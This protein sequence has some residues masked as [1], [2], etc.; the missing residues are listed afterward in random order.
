MSQL[1]RINTSLTSVPKRCRSNKKSNMR[2]TKWGE[3]WEDQEAEMLDW[4]SSVNNTPPQKNIHLTHFS[5]L[6]SKKKKKNISY[7]QMH[8][9]A[10][11]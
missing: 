10:C 4:L 9:P 6:V 3:A 1:I 11:R 8:L 7:T 2:S 5:T